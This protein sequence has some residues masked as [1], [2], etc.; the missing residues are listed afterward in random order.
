MSDTSTSPSWA[1]VD[2]DPAAAG[3]YL[4]VLGGLIGTMKRRSIEML[5][6]RA[7][8]RVLEAG[9]GLGRDAEAMADMVGPDGHVTGT[10][11]S[12]AL[13]T[14]AQART[15]AK[16][17]RLSFRVA[18]IYD[19]PFHANSFDAGRVDRVLQHLEDPAAAVAQ[20][21]WVVRSGGRIVLMEPDWESVSVG[22]VDPAI[23]RLVVARELGAHPAGHVGRDLPALLS[24]AG[25]HDI[26]FELVPLTV[27]DLGT[28][29]YLTGLGKTLRAVVDAGHVPQ[30]AAEAWW[31]GLKARDEDRC[32]L[33]SIIG[34][35]AVGTVSG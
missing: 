24:D 32:F 7:G 10:D 22:G 30:D 9:C 12:H 23:T 34:T 26:N 4:D 13:I 31:A 5:G 25:C 6:L 8:Q 17:E 16:Q 21:A 19:L 15:A 14:E 18:N 11:L 28:F 2:R 27:R 20:I 33:G 35:I 29:D 3:R 1:E